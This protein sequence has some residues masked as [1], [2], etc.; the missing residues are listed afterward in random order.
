[1]NKETQ[2]RSK[3]DSSYLTVLRYLAISMM[4]AVPV[5]VIRDILLHRSMAAHA[6]N[7]VLLLMAYSVAYLIKT[8]RIPSHQ[9]HHWGVAIYLT[10]LIKIWTLIDVTHELAIAQIYIAMHIIVSFLTMSHIHYVINFLATAALWA[11]SLLSLNINPFLE[12][13][14]VPTLVGGA[15]LFSVNL[16]HLRQALLNRIELKTNDINSRAFLELAQ[17]F[18]HHVDSDGR[19]LF[20]N[21]YWLQ[22]L[23]YSRDEIG[24]L[25]VNDIISKEMRKKHHLVIRAVTSGEQVP[26]LQSEFVTKSGE[27]VYVEGAAHLVRQADGATVLQGIYVN[28]SEREKAVRQLKANERRFRSLA[29]NLKEAFWLFDVNEQ[30]ILYINNAILQLTGHTP[31]KW[32]EKPNDVIRAITFEEDRKITGD[33][34]KKMCSGIAFKIE[35]RFRHRDGQERWASMVTSS[36]EAENGN[37]HLIGLSLDITETKRLYTKLEELSRVDGLTGLANRRAFDQTLQLE[38]D[39]HIRQTQSLALLM[40]DIDYFK[41]Y[42]DHYGHLEGDQCLR[43]VAQTAKA[44]TKRSADLVSRYGGEEFAV[45]LPHTDIDGASQIAIR[46]RQEIENLALPHYQSPVG[47]VTV[48]VGVAAFV[49]QLGHST[50]DLIRLADKG[51]YQAKHNG[52]NR[53]CVETIIESSNDSGAQATILA[54]SNPQKKLNSN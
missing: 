33:V 46:I 6:G 3:L 11:A 25:T 36:F 37:R 42:N 10:F 48:S 30:K 16:N 50:Y 45:I 14:F 2:L 40:I 24:G 13:S 54:F 22:T 17:C 9:S 5:F 32:L 39:R 47:K 8:K 52:R 53:I 38:L 20:V 41:Q 7:I 23:G 1:M 34:I 35:H 4:M 15:V 43:T 28:R 12:P 44:V 18:I 19:F 49:P 31:E 26:Q 27:I 51:L 29:E 21:A